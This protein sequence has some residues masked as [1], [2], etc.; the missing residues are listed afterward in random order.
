MQRL[1]RAIKKWRKKFKSA[2]NAAWRWRRKRINVL[3]KMKFACIAANAAMIAIARRRKKRMNAAVI[4]DADVISL[5]LR[6]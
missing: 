1:W 5:D 3:V 6:Y 2:K 4:A